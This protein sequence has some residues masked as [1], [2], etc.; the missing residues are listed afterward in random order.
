MTDLL[1]TTPLARTPPMG[2]NT[3]NKFGCSGI[4]GQVLMDMADR[5]IDLGLKEAHYEFINSD[6]CWMQRSP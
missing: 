5:F 2:F 3:W 6:D 1:A 4:S